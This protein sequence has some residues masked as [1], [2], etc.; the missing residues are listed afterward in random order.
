MSPSTALP[1]SNVGTGVSEWKLPRP[2]L[3]DQFCYECARIPNSLLF[4]RR[5]PGMDKVVMMSVPGTLEFVVA[6]EQAMHEFPAF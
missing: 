5:S 4:W 6:A 2:R 1:P 3:I